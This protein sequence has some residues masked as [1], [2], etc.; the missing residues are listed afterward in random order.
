MG[1]MM[2][3]V[4]VTLLFGIALFFTVMRFVAAVGMNDASLKNKTR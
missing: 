4:L 1:V 3:I 2:F